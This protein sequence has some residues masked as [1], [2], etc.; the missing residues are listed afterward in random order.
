MQLAAGQRLG[1]QVSEQNFAADLPGQP[2]VPHAQRD[3]LPAGPPPELIA[4]IAHHDGVGTGADDNASSMGVMLELARRAAAGSTRERGLRVRVHRRR[5]H[6]RPGRGVLR[7]ALAAG[8]PGGGGD[9][10]GLGGGAGRHAD[11]DRDPAGHA[12]RHVADAVSHRPQRDPAHHRAVAGGARPARPA[13]RPGRSPTPWASRGRC[14]PASVPARDADRRPAARPTCHVHQLQPRSAGRRRQRDGQPGRQLDG[15]SAIE[16]GGR[17]DI[18]LGTRTVRGL[19]GR[20]GAGGAARP[21]SGVH[22]GH[23]RALPAAPDRRWRRR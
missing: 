20:D 23:G 13:L 5:H 14:W 6:R 18:F 16:P 7:R 8:R 15:A 10:A 3:R 1:Y 21:G 19:A 22:A 9:R 11:P 4:V 12:P 2:N 17:P